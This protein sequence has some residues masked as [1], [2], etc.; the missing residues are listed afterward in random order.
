MSKLK[1]RQFS[2]AFKIKIV[3]FYESLQDGRPI[4]ERSLGFVCK[5]AH[6]HRQSLKKWID[7]KPA[8]MVQHQKHGRKKIKSKKERCECEAME[9]KLMNW[10][11]TKRNEGV[12]IDGTSIISRGK[13]IYDEIHPEIEPPNFF[14]VCDKARKSFLF[15]RG[16]LEKFLE[17]RNYTMRRITS[18]GRDLPADTLKRINIYYNEVRNF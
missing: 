9:L 7:S 11:D 14:K 12:C 13:Q 6:I 10:I 5:T 16:W 17:R 3:N 18:T 4:R 2:L 8:L 15:S 1:L